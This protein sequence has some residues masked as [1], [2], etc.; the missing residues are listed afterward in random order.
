MRTRLKTLFL[1]NLFLFCSLFIVRQIS[2]SQNQ[3]ISVKVPPKT[4]DFQLA[5]TSDTSTTVPQS[6]VMIYEV[7]YGSYV[8]YNTPIQIEAAWQEGTVEGSPSPSVDVVDYVIGSAATAYGG[9]SAMV[10]LVNRKITWTIN[11][12]PA[13]TTDKTVTFKLKTNN[14]YQGGKKVA[15]NVSAKLINSDITLPVQSVSNRYLFNEALVT[16]TPTP[17][18]TTAPTSTPNTTSNS[19]TQT[20]GTTPIPTAASA[21]TVTPTPS[22]PEITNVTINSLTDN[23]TTLTIQ[24]ANSSTLR[25]SYGTN[26]NMINTITTLTPATLNEIDISKLEPDKRY[27]IQIISKTEDGKSTKSDIF[28]I[29]TPSISTAPEVDKQS[30][31]ITSNNNLLF[32]PLSENPKNRDQ[33]PVIVIPQEKIYDFRFRVKKNQKAKQVKAIVK[34]KYVLGASTIKQ[35]EANSE[36]IIMTEVEPGVFAGRLKT[37]SLS[38]FYEIAAQISDYNGNIAYQKIADLKVVPPFT[39][40]DQDKKPIEGARV[41]LS[42]FNTQKNIYSAISPEVLPIENPMYS[43]NKGV[44]D[45]VLPKGKYKASIIA[46]G[47]EK[48]TVEF[49]IGA[50]K[51]KEFPL[52]QL[53][54]QPMN[55]LT[56]VEYYFSTVYDFINSGFFYLNELTK[57]IR[58]AGL[59]ETLIILTSLGIAFVS[60]SLKTHVPVDALSWFIVSKTVSVFKKDYLK[61]HII[62]KVVNQSNEPEKR[63]MVYL[64]DGDKNKILNHQI[65]NAFGEFYFKRAGIKNYKLL[66]VKNGFE[67]HPFFEFSDEAVSSNEMIKLQIQENKAEK[68]YFLALVESL[69]DNSLGFIFSLA[70][71][72]SIFFEILLGYSQGWLKVLPFLILSLFNFTIWLMFFRKRP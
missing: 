9:T 27:Y 35:E 11:S 1:I 65:S 69:I 15:F 10:D 58:F 51:E 72:N 5:I 28:I 6:S 3:Q 32:S 12:F 24:T 70:L 37:P 26:L 52:V 64:I 40:L 18:P 55:I 29:K 50:I 68:N 25:I 48:Q 21:P 2:Y 17:T 43:D 36:T 56:M 46:V 20:T 13:R 33:S 53:K 23:E 45:L 22:K 42:L 54:R 34:N 38:G 44:V 63:A 66:V 31:I 62:G 41:F 49:S 30:L 59:V 67:P 39:V 7:T 19:E 71:A 14:N 60:I 57:S 61:N 47:Y 4:S 16:P 8:Y